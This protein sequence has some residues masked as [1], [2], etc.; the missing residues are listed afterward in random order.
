MANIVK[1]QKGGSVITGTETIVECGHLAKGACASC[2]IRAF[3]IVV[4]GAVEKGKYMAVNKLT[5]DW[6]LSDQDRENIEFNINYQMNDYKHG[7]KVRYIPNHADGD[8]KHRDC[9][10]GVVSSVTEMFVFVKYDN[11]MCIMTTGDEPYTA[12]ATKREN[13]T[14]RI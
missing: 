7:D 3:D 8:S 12:Q 6:E 1:I 10:D 9:Q 14:R 4:I 13:L 2:V 5:A 11:L